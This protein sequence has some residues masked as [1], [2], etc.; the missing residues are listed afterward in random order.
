MGDDSM[1]FC[2]TARSFFSVCRSFAVHEHTVTKLQPWF[3]YMNINLKGFCQVIWWYT[4][5]EQK[6][7][8]MTA[9]S[10]MMELFLF[11]IRSQSS[12]H[13]AVICSVA[14]TACP[15]TFVSMFNELSSRLLPSMQLI[16]GVTDID[17][18]VQTLHT[19]RSI[20]LISPGHSHTMW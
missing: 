14:Q 11:F 9:C 13:E 7:K 1:T 2:V 6:N 8:N 18:Q 12:W 19:N 16:N 17:E 5:L 3:G 20:S 15:S 4:S 10:K